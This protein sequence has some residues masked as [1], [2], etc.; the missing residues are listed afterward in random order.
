MKV[1]LLPSSLPPTEAQFL[2]SF[3]VNDTVTIDAGPLGLLSDLRKQERVR[4][5][6]LTHEHID[7]IATLPILLVV[8]AVV[9]FGG[10]AGAIEHQIEGVQIRLCADPGLGFHI[11]LP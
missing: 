5:V 9:L 3:L 8:I 10:I 2:V 1:E 7:H 6:F 4:H 11:S